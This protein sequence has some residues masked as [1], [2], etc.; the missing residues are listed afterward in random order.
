MPNMPTVDIRER[1]ALGDLGHHM[2]GPPA[3]PRA[4]QYQARVDDT[5]VSP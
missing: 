3:L 4:E 2:Q 1:I 5:D